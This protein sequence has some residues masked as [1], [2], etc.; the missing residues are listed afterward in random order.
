MD[1]G[2]VTSRAKKTATYAAVSSAIF[3]LSE[4][5]QILSA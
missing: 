4:Q 5:G 3:S 1:V 2:L